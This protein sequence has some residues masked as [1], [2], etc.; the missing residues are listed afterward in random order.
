MKAKLTTQKS[1]AKNMEDSKE[2]ISRKVLAVIRDGK[3]CI[4]VDVRWYM[5]RTSTASV[6]YCSVW[7]RNAGFCTS[8]HGSAGGGGYHKISAAFADALE[9][10]GI[11]LDAYVAGGGDSAV[12]E[13]M[14]AIG[15]TL[16]Y[17]GHSMII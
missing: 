14:K 16:G 7:V 2:A 11:T 4:P 10:A 9:S 3:I 5:G 17:R 12:D 13:A 6:V 15:R 1:N 8:G